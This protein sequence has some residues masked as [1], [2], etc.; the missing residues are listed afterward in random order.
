[1]FAHNKWLRHTA[2]VPKGFIRYRVLEALNEKPMSG[3]E[4]MTDIEK[5]TGG[6]W[7]PSPGSIYPLLAWLQ[8]NGHVKELPMENGLKRYELTESGKKLLAEQKKIRRQF[9]EE[10]GFLPA[11]FF[12]NILMKR[13]PPEKTGAIH[14]SMRRL[15]IA[16]FQ[17]GSTLQE[18]FSEKALDESLKVVN[19]ATRKFEEIN[20]KLKGEKRE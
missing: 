15:A 9:R 12:D 10:V 20:K 8:D 17:L 18:N 3:S 14:N 7:K 5:Q 11:P 4:I 2:M 16:F 1:M 13:I 19:E 6:F